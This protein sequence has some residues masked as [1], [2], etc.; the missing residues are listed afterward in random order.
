[1]KKIYLAGPDVFKPNAKEIG[2]QLVSTVDKYGFKGLFPLYNEIPQQSSKLLTGKIIALENIKMIQGC[3]IVLAN[4]EPFRGPSADC[5]TVWECAYAKGLG[6]K[7]Y[8][9]NFDSKKYK[10]KVIGK[11]AHDNMF[12]EDFDTWDNIMLVWGIDELF[13]N[14]Q[15][16]LEHMWSNN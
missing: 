1:M 11:F 15:P 9:Y 14:I 16:A 12:V 3:D 13:A 4:L 6:K 2:K 10:D 8:G 7:V 5:G